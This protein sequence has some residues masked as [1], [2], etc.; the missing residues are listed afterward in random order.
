MRPV[1]AM[2]SRAVETVL[3]ASGVACDADVRAFFRAVTHMHAQIEKS[4]QYAC[5]WLD[6]SHASDSLHLRSAR[7]RT[8]FH[9]QRV[10]DVW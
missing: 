10:S 9:V 4:T 2:D 8:M 5:V 3:C 6:F 1:G 7:S